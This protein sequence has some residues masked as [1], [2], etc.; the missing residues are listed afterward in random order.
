MLNVLVIDGGVE[1]ETMFL[2]DLKYFMS[3][4]RYEES[5]VSYC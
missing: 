5:A 3:I 1:F 2:T 4:V